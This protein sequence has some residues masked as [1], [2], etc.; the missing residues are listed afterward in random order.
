MATWIP[1]AASLHSP[2]SVN[3]TYWPYPCCVTALDRIWGRH[4]MGKD[5]FRQHLSRVIDAYTGSTS[6]V[7]ASQ[8]LQHSAPLG[9]RSQCRER[10]KTHTHTFKKNRA[11]SSLIFTAPTSTTWENALMMKY[12]NGHQAERKFLSA[13]CASSSSS[14]TSH[15]PYQVDS[16]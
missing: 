6:V 13:P 10:K 11:S 5:K 7:H 15:N 8:L 1:T 12:C 14:M 16:C 2:V 3:R 9:Q 4:N